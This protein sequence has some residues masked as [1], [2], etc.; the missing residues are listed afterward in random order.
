MTVPVVALGERYVV[1]YNPMKFKELL[2]LASAARWEAEPAEMFS[3]VDHLLVALQTAVLQIPQDKLSFK[4]PDRDRDLQNFSVHIAHRV[5]R[6][7]DAARDLTF[8]ADTKAM[9]DT[10]AQPYDTPAKIA[11]YAAGV[12]QRLRSWRSSEGDAPLNQVVDAYM[13]QVTLLQLFEMITNHT[14][15]HL[16]QLYAFMQQLGISPKDPLAVE[17]LRG[18]TVLDSVF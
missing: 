18:V 12:Q 15:H 11:D 3:A 6:G 10:A 13:G 1:G 16:R 9:H 8:I 17:R 7:L 4:S 14:A 2:N 5:Q